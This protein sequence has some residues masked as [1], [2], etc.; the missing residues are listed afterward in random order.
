MINNFP[1]WLIVFDYFLACLMIILL[2]NF[3]FNLF[4]SEV[5]NFVLYRFI[6]KLTHPIINLTNKITPSFIV[7]PLIPMYIAWM[8]F[9]LRVYLLPLFLGYSYVG[10]FAF[11]FEKDLITQVKSIFLNIAIN[12]NY[13]M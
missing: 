13:G 6:S 7:R 4:L 12:L 5:S 10:K 8:I 1:I 9:M 2:I 11:T 3:I